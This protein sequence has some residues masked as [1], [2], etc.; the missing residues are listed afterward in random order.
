MKDFNETD[1]PRDQ[2]YYYVKSKKTQ[3]LVHINYKMKVILE[4]LQRAPV[5]AA[6]DDGDGALNAGG[7]EMMDVVLSQ[8]PQM[9]DD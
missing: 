3:C 5:R 9:G 7:N 6:C 2:H 4:H 8:S 1:L